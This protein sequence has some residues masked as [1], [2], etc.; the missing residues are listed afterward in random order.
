MTDLIDIIPNPVATGPVPVLFVGGFLGEFMGGPET[1]VREYAKAFA[2]KNP[3]V[4]VQYF[5]WRQGRQIRNWIE[6]QS[7]PPVVFA[8]SYGGD[9]A[10]DAAMKL[11]GRV[12]HLYT[13]DPVGSLNCSPTLKPYQRIRESVSHWTNVTMDPNGVHRFDFWWG[14]DPVHKF[15]SEF[16]NFPRLKHGDFFGAMRALDNNGKLP[17]GLDFD[18]PVP[19][20]APRNI[21]KPLFIGA[22]VLTA[23]AV[24]AVLVARRRR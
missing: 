19:K 18:I 9:R 15:A 4:P 11:P 22:A 12:G 13:I 2:E 1:Q 3:G 16:E 21:K 20:I 8:Q 7:T 17:P 23:V 6:A 14:H 10:A 5:S 24:T